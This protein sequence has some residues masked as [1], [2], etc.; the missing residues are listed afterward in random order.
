M[1]RIY[2]DHAATT[3]TAPE[4]AQ[5]MLPYLSGVYGNA[6]S[7]HSFGLEARTAVEEARARIASFMG[8][9][10]EEIVFTS[11]GTESDNF[12][13]KGFALSRRNKGNHIITSSIEHHAVLETCKFLQGQG[14][15]VTYLPVDGNGLVNPDDVKKAITAGTILISVMHGNNEIG[16]IEPIAEIGAVAREHGVAFHSDAVQ[17][18]G[19]IPIDVNDLQVD[20][21]SVSAHKLYGPK[22]IGLAYVRNG[23]KIIPLLHGGDQERRRRASTL[24]VP[25]I[26]GFGRAVELAGSDMR[27]ELSRQ[28]VLRD[29]L[30]SGLLSAVEDSRLNGHPVRRLPNNVNIS[31]AF[32]EGEGLLLSLDMEGIAVSTGSACTSSSLEPSHVL[33]AIG[34][35]VELAHGSLR[36]SLGRYTT[37]Q[38]IERVLQVMPGIVHRLRAMSPLARK[39]ATA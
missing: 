20:F 18:F 38:D 3:P 33:A 30:A 16:T 23:M 29:R 21:L 8:A 9:K 12:I 1:K 26:V 39:G 11:G 22:G 4:V 37:Q 6:S 15:S 13:I 25:G 35:P 2:L 34:L 36:F 32:V 10:P 31:F 17:T 27:A 7:L 5:A 14:F 24:N 28:S 19:H